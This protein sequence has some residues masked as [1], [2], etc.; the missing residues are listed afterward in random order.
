MTKRD[1]SACFD[2]AQAQ[3][4]HY[5]R[6]QAKPFVASGAPISCF[7]CA[8]PLADARGVGAYSHSGAARHHFGDES[9]SSRARSRCPCAGQ[10]WCRVW[11][12][13]DLAGHGRQGHGGRFGCRRHCRRCPEATEGWRFYF[14]KVVPGYVL[15]WIA[16]VLVSKMSPLHADVAADF[17]RVL[18]ATARFNDPAVE[19]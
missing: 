6:S 12:G 10:S 14:C 19:T 1:R 2:A 17:N 15:C 8:R 4:N 5:E 11:S 9:R 16:V 18:A 13:A 3:S 7:A